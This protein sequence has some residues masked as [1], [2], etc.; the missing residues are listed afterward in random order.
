[1]NAGETVFL[2]TR[3]TS[4]SRVNPIVGVYDANNGYVI[5]AGSGRPFDG[6]AEV[7]ITQTGTYYAL[8]RDGGSAGGLLEQYLLDVQIQPTSSVNFPNLQVT[9]VAPPTGGTIQSGQP[10]SYSFTVQNTGSLATAV[11]L[12]TDR[13]LLSTNTVGGDADDLLL[14]VYPHAGILQPGATYTVSRTAPCPKG[15]AAITT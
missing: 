7:R 4:S 5:E 6:V 3:K 12:W 11:S 14:G 13:V 2:S 1:V 8:M 10:I 9:S 15:S